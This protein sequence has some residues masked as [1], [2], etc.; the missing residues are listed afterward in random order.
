MPPSR[1]PAVM[2]CAVVA[3]SRVA[4]TG[5]VAMAAARRAR[6]AGASVYLAVVLWRS[7]GRAVVRI[8]RKSGVAC[9]DR[10]GPSRKIRPARTQP[11]FALAA[12]LVSGKTERLGLRR[13]L[14]LRRRA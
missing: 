4:M 3:A 14:I 8:A 1:A 9:G 10:R 6:A 12:C 2:A 7:P 11:S 5:H 13:G